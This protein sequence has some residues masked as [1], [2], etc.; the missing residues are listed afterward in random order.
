MQFFFKSSKLPFRKFGWPMM[1]GSVDAILLSIERVSAR[2]QECH[3]KWN[4]N[5]LYNC[6]GFNTK[7]LKTKD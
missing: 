7:R 5:C 4:Y 2:S 1:I 6:I 3:F